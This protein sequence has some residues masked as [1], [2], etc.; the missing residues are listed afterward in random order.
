MTE[1]LEGRSAPD[2]L[3]QGSD[4][5]SVLNGWFE[6]NVGTHSATD[7][8]MDAVRT[9]LEL[10]RPTVVRYEDDAQP[11][12]VE[13]GHDYDGNGAPGCPTVRAVIHSVESQGFVRRWES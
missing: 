2:L 8:A 12:C 10:H 7:A 6:D 13:C 5:Q 9:I 3:T 11:I 4:V 1:D